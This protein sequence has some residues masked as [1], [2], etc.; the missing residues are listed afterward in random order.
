MDC[1]KPVSKKLIPEEINRSETSAA[2]GAI[3]INQLQAQIHRAQTSVAVVPNEQ[4]NE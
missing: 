1:G 4:D 2:V 3:N